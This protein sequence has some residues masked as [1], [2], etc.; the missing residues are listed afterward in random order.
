MVVIAGIDE[1]QEGV[2]K[3]PTVAVEDPVVVSVEED[4][5]LL[6]CGRG[7]M[8]PRSIPQISRSSSPTA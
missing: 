1:L 2:D 6:D 5:A 3:F 7:G 8:V 4:H